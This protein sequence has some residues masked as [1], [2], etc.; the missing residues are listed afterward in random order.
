MK[1]KTVIFLRKNLK[2]FMMKLWKWPLVGNMKMNMRVIIIR[3]FVLI[4]FIIIIIIII[5]FYVKF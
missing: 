3:G 5:I 1:M 2:L 4:Y